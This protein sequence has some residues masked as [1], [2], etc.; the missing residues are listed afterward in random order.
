MTRTVVVEQRSAGDGAWLAGDPGAWLPTPLRRIGPDRWSIVVR[1]G[2]V[3]QEV[4][5]R[6]GDVWRHG[7][8]ASRAIAWEPEVED[9]LLHPE[10]LLP[11]LAGEIRWASDPEGGL[12]VEVV[13]RYTPPGMLAGRI[14]DDIGLHRVATATLRDLLERIAARAP[15]VGASRRRVRPAASRR[16]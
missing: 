12:A 2:P 15:G 1:A 11:S 5:C 13:G 10:L 4:S 7:R 9:A 16:A 14:L 3:A 6:V 8:R